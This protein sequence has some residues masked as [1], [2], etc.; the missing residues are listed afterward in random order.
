MGKDEKTDP[1]Q[2]TLD[3]LILRAL[4]LNLETAVRT[5]H[6]GRGE[7][8]GEHREEDGASSCAWCDSPKW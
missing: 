8:E 1:L 3:M 4:R 5:G 6:R 7:A 2:G